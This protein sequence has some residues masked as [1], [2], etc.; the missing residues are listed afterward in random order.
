MSKDDFIAKQD[1]DWNEMGS[2]ESH[3]E[4][5]ENYNT[6]L[7][8]NNHK[9]LLTLT[10]QI[11]ERFGFLESNEIRTAILECEFDQ[12]RITK[13]L[14]K[15]EIEGKYKE[16]DAYEWKIFEEKPV[17]NKK[18]G[19]GDKRQNRREQNENYE[20]NLYNQI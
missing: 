13:Y 4:N 11:K 15:Y 2:D 18:K 5:E 17:V 12:D 10:K 16:I 8:Q 9:H 3:E 1:Q 6:A 7:S 14:E 20:Q 19:K